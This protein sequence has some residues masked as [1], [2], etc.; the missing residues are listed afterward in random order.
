MHGFEQ[1]DQKIFVS[2]NRN[3]LKPLIFFPYM[4]LELDIKFKQSI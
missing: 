3:E 4:N 2:R 1:I